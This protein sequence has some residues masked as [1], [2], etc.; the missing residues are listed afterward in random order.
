MSSINIRSIIDNIQDEV[1]KFAKTNETIA[2]HTNLLALNAT[3]EAARAGEYGKGFSVVAQEVKSLASQAATNSKELR[4]TV[5]ARIAKQTEELTSEFESTHYSRLSEMA[6]T[7]VQLIV[8]N[9]YER[10]A[11]VRWWATDEAFHSCLSDPT[12]EKASYAAQRLGLIN[13]FYSVY[14]DLLLVN[15]D[16]KVVAS[17]RADAFRKVE[18]SNV[19]GQRWF[20]QA[21]ATRSGDEYYAD[22]IFNDTLHEGRAVAVYSTAVRRGADVNG[23]VVG[24]L[25]V[26]FDWQ[27]QSRVIVRDE[28]NLS[29]QEWTRSRVLLLDNQMRIIASSDGADLLT[30]FRLDNKGQTKGYYFDDTGRCIAYARTIGYQEFDGLGW[31]GVVVQAPEAELK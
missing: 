5:L 31:W 26:F 29:Q 24:V 23:A 12:P 13:R 11:D 8:R 14:C 30:P 6:Q 28:P 15:T 25:G 9:L 3:I 2:S 4:T 1:R 27:E 10:T 7:L 22:D 20:T 18:G 19:G 17:S 21:M 16:G